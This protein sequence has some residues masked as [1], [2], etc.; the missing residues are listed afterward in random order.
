M[1][2]LYIT[3][4]D[5]HSDGNRYAAVGPC[6]EEITRNVKPFLIGDV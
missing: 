1:F 5:N 6:K 4:D 3:E 2:F